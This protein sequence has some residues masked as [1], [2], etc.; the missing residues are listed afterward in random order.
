VASEQPLSRSNLRIKE[1][2][3]LSRRSWRD[4]VGHFLA[5]GPKAVE[6][7]LLA[8][9]AREVFVNRK[10]A[11]TYAAWRA[12]TPKW[13]V[14][15][16]DALAALSESASTQGIVAVCEHIPLATSEVLALSR[17]AVICADV[18]DPGNAGTVVRTAEA[19]GADIVVF[20]GES[21]D[22]H[23]TRLVRASVGS[24]FRVP[25]AVVADTTAVIEAS[26]SAGL[27]VLAAA[28]SGEVELFSTDELLQN[29]TAWLFGNEA[30]GLPTQVAARADHR[31][32]IP[33][34]GASESLNLATATAVCLYASAK[35]LH[36]T[37]RPR[38]SP[39]E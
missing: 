15:A 7:A 21:V 12:H 5:D 18:R 10:A 33:M 29:R 27:V 26:Q 37:P 4:N 22:V 2:R 6:G 1:A 19:A 11:Q 30:W 28:G 16:D 23:N 32:R 3:K 25:I 13:T 34:S 14:V 31:V 9:L 36:C 24:V 35:A 38:S 39:V 20:S 17:L 8:N